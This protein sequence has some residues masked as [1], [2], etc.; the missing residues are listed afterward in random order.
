MPRSVRLSVQMCARPVL[1]LIVIVVF[2]V[3]VALVTVEPPASSACPMV[4]PKPLRVLY[5]ESTLVA[6]GRV[7]DSVTVEQKQGAGLTRTALHISSLLKGES[8][9]KV[10]NFD[11]Y[12]WGVE[13][14]SSPRDYTKDDVVLV[15]LTTREGGDGYV[16]TDYQRGVKKLSPDDL[17]VYA[18]R[19][20]ELAAIT[21]NPEHD[22]SAITEWLVRCAEEP[23]TRWEGAFELALNATAFQDPPEDE[24]LEAVTDE[25][26][27][28]A[29]P[30]DAA[31]AEEKEA[32]ESGNS[33]EQGAAAGAAGAV[34]VNN[35]AADKLEIDGANIS[36]SEESLRFVPV[37]TPAQNERLLTALLGAE[38]LGEG[39]LML[40]RLVGSWKDA[41]ILPFLLKHLTRMAD[42]PGYEAEDMMRIVAH[43]LGDQTLI[44][45]VANYS[46]TSS[47]ND[48]YDGAAAVAEPEGSE[49]TDEDRAAF[50]KAL[51]E[52]KA[53]AAES[54]FQ[55]RGKLQHFLALAAQPQTP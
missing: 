18:R 16:P 5:M 41:R 28:E 40:V 25:D 24:T 15:F 1:L 44:K 32:D 21:R 47:Y 35:E 42:K 39:E 31:S 27:A 54:L 55:R 53:A 23:A 48:L 4:M 11:H 46:K 49:F 12:V 45:F 6:V 51:E 29:V 10:V 22:A 50:K 37:F 13:D 43:T 30:D 14:A 17:K 26:E 38:E 9:K 2:V 19:I 52:S 3:G 20:E 8:K 34:N 33:V 7:G 36:V